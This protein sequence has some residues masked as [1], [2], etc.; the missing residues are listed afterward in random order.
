MTPQ[1]SKSAENLLTNWVTISLSR[2]AM[3]HVVTYE[4][5]TRPVPLIILHFFLS[6][7]GRA[8]ALSLRRPCCRL[9]KSIP[10]FRQLRQCRVDQQ[11]SN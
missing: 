9:H 7:K 6:F 5:V 11:H 3:L 8:S 4:A 2:R 10:P 1:A